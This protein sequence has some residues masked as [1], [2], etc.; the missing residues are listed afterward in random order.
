MIQLKNKEELNGIRK[1]CKLL[2]SLFLELESY[3][4]EGISTKDIDDFCHEF[5]IKHNAKPILIGY[6]GYPATSCISV[7]E[8]IIHGIP[9]KK[10]ILKNGDLVK[11]DIDLSLNGFVSDSTH[12]FEIGSV[13]SDV[14]A[15]NIETRNALYKGIDAI[16]KKNARLNDASS[17][18]YNHLTQFGY[19]IVRE[20]CG[21][22]VGISVH[23]DPLVFNY[24]TNQGN[25]RLRE[26]MVIAIEP[27]VALKSAKCH[28]MPDGWTVVTNDRSTACHWEHTVAI[29]NDGVEILTEI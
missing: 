23:E 14:H 22:G 8:E 2:A 1:S 20:Y 26:G 28:V 13:N 18:I 7:N 15:L 24:V 3:I 21:H 9:S 11:V 19:G 27:M 17:A 12:A 4:K 10:K 29:T 25:I 16:N 5:I 6:R